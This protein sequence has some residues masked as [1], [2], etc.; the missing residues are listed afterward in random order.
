ML[1][2]VG[3]N[4]LKTGCAEPVAPWLEIGASPSPQ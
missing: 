1:G 4:G 2:E 3:T